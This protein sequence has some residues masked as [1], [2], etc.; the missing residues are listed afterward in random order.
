VKVDVDIE[1]GSELH[2][3][4]KKYARENGI[5]H[6]RAYRELIEKGL[7]ADDNRD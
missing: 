6:P 2:E 1:R 4:V 7:E 5:R 3:R